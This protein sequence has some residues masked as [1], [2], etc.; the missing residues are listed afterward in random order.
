[1]GQPTPGPWM[2]PEVQ[3]DRGVRVLDSRGRPVARVYAN[4]DA[5]YA[6]AHL[7]ASAPEL[8][9]VVTLAVSFLETAGGT[10]ARLLLGVGGVGLLDKAR[11]VL[12]KAERRGNES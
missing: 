5:R 7:I 12:R 11:V 6:N 2:A 9:E 10:N 3:K 1:M 4:G 8:L